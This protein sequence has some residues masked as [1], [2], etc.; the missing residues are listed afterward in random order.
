MDIHSDQTMSKGEFAKLIN[1]SAGRISQYIA[2]GQIGPD[3]LQGE[4]TGDVSERMVNAIKEF[5]KLRGGR[6]TGVLNPQ[7]RGHWP[8]PPGGG[9]RMPAGRSSAI[10]APAS[11][12]H[13]DQARAA[14]DQRRQRRQ[15]DLADRNRPDPAGAAQ[16]SQSDHGQIPPSARRKRPTARSTTPSWKLDFFVLSGLQGLKKFYLRGTFK[17]DEVRILTHSLRSGRTGKIP[18]SRS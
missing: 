11:G 12:W 18:W 8:I 10:P 15:M 17:G 7:E 9:R 2:S 1:V 3:A 6:E 16:G 14:A 4:V 13:S 5:Q